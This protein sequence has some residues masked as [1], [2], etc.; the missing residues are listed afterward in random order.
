MSTFTNLAAA[1][2]ELGALR[3]TVIVGGTITVI[4]ALAAVFTLLA[5]RIDWPG[6]Y[7]FQ[8]QRKCFFEYMWHSPKLLKGGSGDELALFALI[9]FVPFVAAAIAIP[10][11]LLRWL[12]RR[13]EGIR[14]MDRGSR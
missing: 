13:R 9:W 5:E 2:R 4:L 10:V 6:A 12:K 8:C 3:F 1:Y 11:L 14:P 7:G